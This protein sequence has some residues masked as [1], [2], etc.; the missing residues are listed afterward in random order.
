MSQIKPTGKKYK[1]AKD[2]SI[3]CFQNGNNIQA[4]WR[5]VI[6]FVTGKET[7]STDSGVPSSSIGKAASSHEIKIINNR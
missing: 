7:V 2:K 6:E 4:E 1:I 3:L 5:D